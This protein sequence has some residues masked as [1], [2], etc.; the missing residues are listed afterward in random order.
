[1]YIS[2]D[3]PPTA[4][5]VSRTAFYAAEYI[6]IP[7]LHVGFSEGLVGKNYIYHKICS[8]AETTCGVAVEQH[9]RKHAPVPLQVNGHGYIG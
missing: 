6:E 3:L 5:P 7:C 2:S 4:L 1:M 9:T 8:F